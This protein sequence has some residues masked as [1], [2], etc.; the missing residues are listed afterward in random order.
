MI[1]ISA[2]IFKTFDV[3]SAVCLQVNVSELGLVT[4]GGKVIWGR[5]FMSD[6]H[7]TM[8]ISLFIISVIYV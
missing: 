6:V 4:Q 8:C 2:F 3:I 7:H 5:F 1:L